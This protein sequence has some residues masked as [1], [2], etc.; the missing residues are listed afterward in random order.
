MT[1]NAAIYTVPELQTL[2]VGAFEQAP[3]FTPE[4]LVIDQGSKTATRYARL[5][6]ACY[7]DRRILDTTVREN[8]ER[9]KVNLMSLCPQRTALMVKVC[10]ALLEGHSHTPNFASLEFVLN[11]IDRYGRSQDLYDQKSARQLY[12]DYTDHLRHRLRLSNVGAVEAGSEGSIGYASASLSQ[13]ALRYLCT[14][15]LDI[16]GAV[17]EGWAIKIPQRMQSEK[18]VPAPATTST[19]HELAYAMHTRIFDALVD[20][21]INRTAPPVV[22]HLEDLGFDDLIYYA[23]RTN[24]HNGWTNTGR[25]DWMPYFYRREGV[26]DGTPKEFNELLARH[27][28]EPI[29]T[30]SHKRKQDNNRRFSEYTLICMA[31]EAARHFGYLLLA[32]AG[33]NAAH[34][35]SV[36][37][38]KVRLDKAL[39]L[40][41]TRA[42]KGR[43]GYE[44]QTQ[45]VDLRFAQTTWKKYL[46]LR[47][48]MS[49]KLEHPPKRG[50]FLLEARKERDPYILLSFSSLRMLTLWPKGAPSLA[51]RAARKHRSVNLKNAS[52]N[53]VAMVSALQ[54]ATPQTIERHY[55]FENRR[56]AAQA[57]NAYFEL[58]AESA[59]H[60]Y[61]GVTPIRI[62]EGGEKI[63]SGLCDA[64]ELNGPKAIDGVVDPGLEPRCGAPVSCIFC[65]HY[66]LHADDTDLLQL[67]TMKRWIEVQSRQFS[68]SIDEHFSKFT[69]YLN[70]IDQI[71]AGVNDYSDDFSQRLKAA[72]A[73]FER[74]EQ[75]PYWGAKINA[76]LDM[77]EA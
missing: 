29:K 55:A 15:A 13:R 27:D 51:I 24:N 60:R 22:I 38:G 77:Q 52:G 61:N 5:Y 1:S 33:N 31:N 57:M 11:W 9:A 62:I 12:R 43:A 49:A 47:H 3:E 45:Y 23:K 65:I 17:V 76:L 40:A 66:G 48:W 14:L 35:A 4:T 59:Q 72:Q 74:G 20:A 64:D 71:L 69:P 75:D 36:D 21:I 54:S 16:G 39:G 19:E 32:E 63:S 68:S 46:Q 28:I 7:L 58:Q 41:Q 53:S 2:P 73:R 44:D 8:K 6:R 42:I 70:R 34:L 37:F 50:V 56:E 25:T 10:K 26:F 30:E 67:L 18:E